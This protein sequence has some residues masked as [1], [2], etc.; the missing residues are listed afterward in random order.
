[1]AV[2]ENRG[3]RHLSW[4]T[5]KAQI[6]AAPSTKEETSQEKFPP[7]KTQLKRYPIHRIKKLRKCLDTKHFNLLY[8]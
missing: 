6:A 1:M 7:W 5:R 4:Y 3:F 2:Y 8:Q